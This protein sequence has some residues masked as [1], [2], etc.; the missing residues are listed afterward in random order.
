M[1]DKTPVEVVQA[2]G[3]RVRKTASAILDA[4]ST[5]QLGRCD[6]PGLSREPRTTERAAPRAAERTTTRAPVAAGAFIAEPARRSPGRGP[7][8]RSL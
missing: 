8:V 1:K 5:V 7:A 4:L 6:P 2:T 3:E